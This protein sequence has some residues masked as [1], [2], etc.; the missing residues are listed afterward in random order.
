M[1]IITILFSLGI[2][3]LGVFIMMVSAVYL[4]TYVIGE[5][6]GWIGNPEL[7]NHYLNVL[8]G[9]FWTRFEVA[10]DW[11]WM[12]LANDHE[13]QA[14]RLLSVGYKRLELG[15]D[16]MRSGRSIEASMAAERA[17]GYLSKAIRT[18]E[19]DS[20]RWLREL[21]YG[22]LKYD[23]VLGYMEEISTESVKPKI[24]HLRYLSALKSREIGFVSE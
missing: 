15:E 17:V 10:G 4:N 11:L 21:E 9:D 13:E 1:K 19:D 5:S 12:R 23:N 20:D 18:C 14:R 8:P 2:V 3:N 6:K 16:L 22:F 7:K 24:T